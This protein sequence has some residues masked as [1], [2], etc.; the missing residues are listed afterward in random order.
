MTDYYVDPDFTGSIRDGTATQPWHSLADT[1]TNTPWTVINA[2]LVSNPV[3]VYFT[4]RKATSDVDQTSTVQLLLSR[5][6]TSTNRLTLDGLSKFNTSASGP[7]WSNYSGS[8]R[9]SITVT[10]AA[11]DTNNEGS[12]FT[13]RDYC[14]VRGF[15]LKATNQPCI[16]INTSHF[17]F[18]LNEVT[19]QTGA[20]IGPGFIYQHR[21]LADTNHANF[22]TD[23]TI[24]NNYI[25]HTFGEGIYISGNGG[26]G[27]NGQGVP[28]GDNSDT[29]T[30]DNVL[31]EG[32]ILTALGTFGGEGDG[33]DIKDGNTNLRIRNNVIDKQLQ[34]FGRGITVESCDLIENNIVMNVPT[35]AVAITASY[36]GTHGRDRLVIRNNIFIAGDNS[37]LKMDSSDATSSSYWW[38]NTKVQNNTLFKPSATAGD[39]VLTIYGQNNLTIQNN[40]ILGGTST[41]QGLRFQATTLS[42]HDYNSYMV[43]SS[44]FAWISEVGVISYDRADV[45]TFEA[46]AKTV[47]PLLVSES[48][49]YVDTNFQLQ[50]GSPCRDAGTTIATFGNDYFGNARPSGSAWDIG[51]HEYG[52]T[53]LPALTLTLVDDLDHT[54]V[55]R[56]TF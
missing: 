14:T 34:Q 37:A 12:P 50:S 19:A 46:H 53:V 35:N 24:R 33:I 17:I 30:Q 56:R 38:S 39:H 20:A 26:D 22:S 23:I 43:R 48:T 32:N 47:E 11:F 5:T 9:F 44:D 52:A 8:S 54:L 36:N 55:A 49:P 42:A 31:I 18:E 1:V 29:Q 27:G 45:N 28:P 10:T 51:A 15:R 6:D 13:H 40:I 2:A 41:F 25:H 4:A 16:V 3:Q 21:P 7:S